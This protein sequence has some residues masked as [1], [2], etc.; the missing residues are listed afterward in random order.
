[1]GRGYIQN[2]SFPNLQFSVVALGL[3]LASSAHKWLVKV[4]FKLC[5]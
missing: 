4:T 5:I 3:T 2:V 1:M